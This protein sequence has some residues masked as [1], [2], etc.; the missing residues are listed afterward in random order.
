VQGL[1]VTYSTSGLDLQFDLAAGLNT[2]G[3]KE[4]FYITGGGANFAL[5]AQ[6]DDAGRVSIGIGNVST[7]SLGNASYGF[8][9]SLVNGGVN[10]LSSANLTTSQQIVTSAIQQVADLSGRLGAF[11]DYT[12][13][14]TV[15]AL[16]VAYENSNAAESSIQDTNFASETSN[17]TR[18]QILSQAATTVLAQA[19]ARPQQA[20]TLLQNA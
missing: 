3:Q 4:S 10:D 7:A 2:A 12:V 8:L 9:D 19:N 5:G 14:S 18:A 13:G 11:Q 17:L 20:L 16:N 15:A 6:V 1:H